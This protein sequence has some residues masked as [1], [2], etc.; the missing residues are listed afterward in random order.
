MRPVQTG[1]I[2]GIARSNVPN[3]MRA[4]ALRKRVEPWARELGEFVRD[5]SRGALLRDATRSTSAL[6]E[7]QKEFAWGKTRR[8][9]VGR[10]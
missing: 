10:A 6:H 5:A 8:T 1:T 2:T 9:S 4:D 7:L 3:V